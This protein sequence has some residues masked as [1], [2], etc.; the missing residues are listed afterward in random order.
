MDPV[1]AAVGGGEQRVRVGRLQLRRPAP[2]QETTGKGVARRRQFLQDRG[3]RRPLTAR[4]APSARQAQTT[5]EDVSD[6]LGRADLEGASAQI[7]DL[8]LEPGEGRAEVPGELGQHGAVDAHACGLHAG[9]HGHHRE[10]ELLVD[11]LRGRALQAGREHR[12]EPEDGVRDLCRHRRGGAGRD[13]LRIDAAAALAPE[14]VG[15]GRGIPQMPGRELRQAMAGQAGLEG[16]GHEPDVVGSRD[17][18]AKAAGRLRGPLQVVHDLADT[19]VLHQGADG[20]PGGRGV[21]LALCKPA[22][23]TVAPGPMLDRHVDGAPGLDR[24]AQPDGAR[25]AAMQVEAEPARR[26]RR[27]DPAVE[28]VL[29]G[30]E[31]VGVG[32]RGREGRHDR[33][34][35]TWSSGRRGGELGVRRDAV[36]VDAEF[37]GHPLRERGQLERLQIGDE[38]P[39]VRR[40]QGQGVGIDRQIHGAVEF[41]QPPRQAGAFGGGEEVL[42]ALGL[43]DRR[44]AL[45]QGLEAPVLEEQLRGRLEADAG[46]AGDVVG[47]VADQRQG[48]ADLAGLQALPFRDHRLDVEVALGPVAGL[49]LRPAFRVVEP[50]ARGDELLQVLVG[51]HDDDLGPLGLGGPRVGGDQVVGLRAVEFDHGQPEGAHGL[52]YQRHLR[53]EVRRRL[54]AVG[55]VLGVELS[56]VR[57]ARTLVEDDTEVCRDDARRAVANELEELGE[58]QPHRARRQAVGGTS[59]VFRVLVQ[60]LMVGAE[61]ER[62]RVDEDEPGAGTEGERVGHEPAEGMEFTETIARIRLLR[63]RCPGRRRRVVDG[64]LRQTWAGLRLGRRRCRRLGR[65]LPRPRP[66]AGA[67]VV[68]PH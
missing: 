33:A 2:V 64:P 20:S 48:V 65:L 13:G 63:N 15:I 52:A 14:R 68:D 45:Q 4:R 46:H 26:A 42:P 19:R 62:A 61:D 6:L 12:P 41:D 60:R 36:G 27:R 54:G 43:L 23:E 3:T 35:G 66:V 5:E 50:D 57:L 32:I 21:D 59:V 28:V 11:R 31:P 56:P 39:A 38:A 40:R 1:G 55:L 7:V 47:G 34:V 49:A 51:R 37:L 8:C 22:E 25:I 10:L 9:E 16:V 30:D 24:Y 44:G 17:L 53:A 18:E 58:E 67:D 29:R